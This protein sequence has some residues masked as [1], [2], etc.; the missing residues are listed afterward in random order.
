MFKHYLPLFD[1]I[2]W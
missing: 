1:T 2:C